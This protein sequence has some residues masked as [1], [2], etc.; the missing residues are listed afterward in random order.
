MPE[1]AVKGK[2]IKPFES[3]RMGKQVVNV[4]VFAPSFLQ[5]GAFFAVKQESGQEHFEPA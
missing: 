2:H 3:V 5:D 4:E 1:S